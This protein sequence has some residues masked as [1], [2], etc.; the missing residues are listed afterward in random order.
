MDYRR[1]IDG[2]RALSVLPV[3]LFYAD[4]ETFNGGFVGVVKPSHRVCCEHQ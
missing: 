1:E 4:F 2:L 3:I